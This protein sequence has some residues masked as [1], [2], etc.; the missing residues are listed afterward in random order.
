MLRSSPSILVALVAC[1]DPRDEARS[2]VCPGGA[3]R[4][5]ATIQ[6]AIDDTDSGGTIT[7]CDGIFP[8]RLT[9][10]GKTL[11]LRSRNG[12]AATT[13]DAES[14]GTALTLS[15]SAAVT[16]KGFA[17]KNGLSEADGGNIY[18]SSSSLALSHSVVQAGEANKGGG[19]AAEACTITISNTDFLSNIATKSEGGGAY[20]T[21]TSGTISGSLFEDNDA[22]NGG[23]MYVS[24]DS[25]TIDGN[26]FISNR[27]SAGGGLYVDGDSPIENN[28]FDSN[29]VTGDIWT[30]IGGGAYALNHD[31]AITGNTVTNNSAV[32]DG[33][34]IYLEGGTAA[35]NGNTFTDNSSFDD[36]GGLRLKLSS[37][38]VDNN[39]FERNWA[40]QTGGGMAITHMGTTLSGNVFT[41]NTSAWGGAL[42]LYEAAST[43]SFNTYTRNIATRGGGAIHIDIGWDPIFFEDEAFE[44]NDANT[45]GGSVF[46]DSP[47]RTGLGFVTSFV[48][49]T[50]GGGTAGRGGAIYVE[51]G[52]I[53]VAN[54]IITE[55]VATTS[56][57]GIFLEGASGSISNSVFWANTA[58][59]GAA[60]SVENSPSVSV[61]NTIISRNT[62][63]AA[64]RVTA[65]AAPAW[66]YMDMYGNTPRDFAGV[67]PV[68]VGNVVFVPLFGD[69]IGGDFSLKTGSRLIDAGD[70]AILDADGLRS[71]IGAFG[72]PGGIW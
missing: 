52:E 46:I 65:G 8:E 32:K 28:L 34:G 20:L 21:A 44:D 66:S 25:L 54:T 3:Y 19:I 14:L 16:V 22:Y 68:G 24:G 17:F 59:Q 2:D 40:A 5:Y 27:A 41:D 18:C 64:V 6:A 38:S 60:L 42:E 57:G 62:A 71:D 11:T 9:I 49:V 36:G 45:V 63:S 67:P 55:N 50:M 47:A 23:G 39:V 30:A 26:D 51:E 43:L 37:A 15:G 72:G 35:V 31:G 7:V 61:R 56:G 1:P 69:A 58:P 12:S 33:G 4:P 29:A 10:S 48:R 13:V 70:P 53:Q